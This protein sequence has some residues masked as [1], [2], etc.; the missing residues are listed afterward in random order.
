[1]TP[2]WFSIF[3]AGATLIGGF[4]ILFR[5]E[6]A[7]RNGD[8]LTAVA[9]GVLV[10]MSLVDVVPEAISSTKH[11]GL[12]AAM[13]FLA[14]YFLEHLSGDP[15]CAGDECPD[16][17]ISLLAYGALLAHSLV[18]GIALTASSGISKEFGVLVGLGVLLHEFPEGLASGALLLHRGF[19]KKKIFFLTA[20]VALATP[21]GTLLSMYV[22]PTGEHLT[23]PYPFLAAIAGSFIYTGVAGLLIHSHRR[24]DG[25]IILSFVL[26]FSVFLIRGYFLQQ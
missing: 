15:H 18:D 5:F 11:A 4:L 9:A 12:W 3:A 7:K 10:S 16:R 21:A 1:M 22:L 2:L 6:W 17:D 24:K 13:G 19:S 23:W 25:S 8:R 20:I 26:G 14:M